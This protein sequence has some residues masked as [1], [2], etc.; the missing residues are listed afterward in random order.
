MRPACLLRK[1]LLLVCL[2]Q[3]AAPLVRAAAG[4]FEDEA[5]YWDEEEQP[6]TKQT[7]YKPTPAPEVRASVNAT[8]QP[9]PFKRRPLSAADYPLELLG[10]ALVVLYAFNTYTGAGLPADHKAP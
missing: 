10:L 4:S 6:T 1:G 7:P 2:L 5:D 8:G 3:L 9:P